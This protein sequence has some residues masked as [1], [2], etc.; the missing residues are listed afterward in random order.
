MFLSFF[1]AS[2]DK[3]KEVFD[4]DEAVLADFLKCTQYLTSFVGRVEIFCHP[5]GIVKLNG[6][7][8]SSI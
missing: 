6:F 2:C 5:S 1:L 3:A 8:A 7:E 4:H